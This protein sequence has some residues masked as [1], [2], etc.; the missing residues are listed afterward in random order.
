MYRILG[1]PRQISPRFIRFFLSSVNIDSRQII[2]SPLLLIG[3]D[4]GL[5]QLN[6]WSNM[7]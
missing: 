2:T 1:N 5:L 3:L 6:H 4:F 7:E